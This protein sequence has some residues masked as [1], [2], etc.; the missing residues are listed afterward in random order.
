MNL[1]R[2]PCLS[3]RLD[4]DDRPGSMDT[5]RQNVP[6]IDRPRRGQ[7]RRGSVHPVGRWDSYVHRRLPG[8]LRRSEALSMLSGLLLRHH[9]CHYRR[10]DRFRRLA[11]LQ[12]GPHRRAAEIFRDKYR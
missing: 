2:L 5:D 6:G 11:L 12:Q 1:L 4:T 7:L 8:L 3:V 9:A 10:T